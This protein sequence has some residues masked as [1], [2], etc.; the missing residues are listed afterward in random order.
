[1]IEATERRRPAGQRRPHPAY[2]KQ[3]LSLLFLASFAT[4]CGGGT[5]RHASGVPSPPRPEPAAEGAPTEREPR[6]SPEAEPRSIEE[7]EE[8]IERAR[9]R[10]ALANVG[11]RLDAP[12]DASADADGSSSTSEAPAKASAVRQ[13]DMC[14]ESCRALAS[15]K[16]AVNALCRMTRDD[17]ARCVGA[18][19]TLDENVKRIAPCACDSSP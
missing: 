2:T 4:S 9:K 8:L 19:R 1:M 14:R 18:R 13:D 15:M 10:L 16:R 3:L 17:D 6:D 11:G 7:A 12:S 5:S